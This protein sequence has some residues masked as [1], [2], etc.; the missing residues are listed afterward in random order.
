MQ[1]VQ[2]GWRLTVLLCIWVMPVEK[3][4]GLQEDEEE[5]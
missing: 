2:S 3:P 1:E 5:L 4:G